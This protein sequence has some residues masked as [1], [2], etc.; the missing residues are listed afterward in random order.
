MAGKDTGIT[1]VPALAIV[2]QQ[3]KVIMGGKY[4][5]IF[6]DYQRCITGSSGSVTPYLYLCSFNDTLH[7][8]FFPI[9]L[10]DMVGFSFYCPDDKEYLAF[11][12]ISWYL[13]E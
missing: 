8:N 2:F 3:Q 12:I 4:I 13:P 6:P 10:M 1:A 9:A 5:R 11:S 7:L